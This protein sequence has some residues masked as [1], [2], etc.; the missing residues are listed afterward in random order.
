MCTA[1]VE[2]AEGKIDEI[3]DR[4]SQE[5]DY[6]GVSLAV[7]YDDKVYFKQTGYADIAIGRS[8]NNETMFR[9]YSLTKG[10]TEI[11]ANLL[12]KHGSLDLELPVSF[13]L[14]NIPKYHLRSY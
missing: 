7:S 8:L 6:P 12:V 10:V 3:L 4:I 13:Y 14:Q 11:L 2:A 1:L 5:H 9:M